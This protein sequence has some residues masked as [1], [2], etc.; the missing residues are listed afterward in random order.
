MKISRSCSAAADRR[1][2]GALVGLV[3]LLDVVGVPGE[4][5]IH[6]GVRQPHRQMPVLLGV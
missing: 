6:L 2:A 1:S 5:P 3:A 4:E